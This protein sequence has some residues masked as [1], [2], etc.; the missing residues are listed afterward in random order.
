MAGIIQTALGQALG[1]VGAAALLGK[2]LYEGQAAEEKGI[3]GAKKEKTEE[4]S[5]KTVAEALKNAQK[6]KIDSPKQLYFAEDGTPLATSNELA[7]ALSTQSLHNSLSAK[8][9]ARDKVRA[10]KQMLMKR[11]LAQKE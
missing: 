1:S 4:S 8:K 5:K 2:Q 6:S 7:S 10:R 3:E 11:K 9:R